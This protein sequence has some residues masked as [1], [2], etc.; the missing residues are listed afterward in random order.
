MIGVPL[1]VEILRNNSVAVFRKPM[2]SLVPVRSQLRIGL[3]SFPRRFNQRLASKVLHHYQP[4]ILRTAPVID[5]N[6]DNSRRFIRSTPSLAS[7]IRGS[8]VRVIYLHYLR[9]QI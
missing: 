6:G 5:L 2:I 4:D 1:R 9:K 7:L 8:K 3:D